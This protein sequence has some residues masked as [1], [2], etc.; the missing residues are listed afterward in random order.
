VSFLECLL[1]R[2]DRRM[3]DVVEDAWRSGARFDSWDDR[4]RWDVWTEVLGRHEEIPIEQL[5]GT[6]PVDATLPW[7]HLDIGIEKRFLAKEYRQAM[8]GRASPPCGK[9]V[10][11]QTHHTNLE[12]HDADGRKLVCYACGVECDLSAMREE[13]GG[14]LRKLGAVEAPRRTAEPEGVTTGRT[15]PRG[16]PPHDFRQGDPVRYRLHL[17]RLPPATLVGHLDWIRAL[18]RILRRAGLPLFYSEGFHPKPKM[19]FPPALPL[20][21]TS[22]DEAVDIAL[23]EERDPE[24]VLAA[25]REAA[26]EGIAFR[27][28]LRRE[29]DAKRLNRQIAV[30][31]WIARLRGPEGDHADAPA[32]LLARESIPW[33]VTRRRRPKEVDLRPRSRTCDGSRRPSCR[34]VSRGSA[35]TAIAGCGSGSSTTSPASTDAPRRWWRR[36]SRTRRGWSPP[37]WR[38]SA[39]WRARGT[40]S[41]PSPPG[42]H[43]RGR[44][45]DASPRA[46]SGMRGGNAPQV[47]TSNRGRRGAPPRI[48]GGRRRAPGACSGGLRR[49]PRGGAR[50]YRRRG[51]VPPCRA[52]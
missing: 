48:R 20:G 42:E 9:P 32:R 24:E 26:P 38:G 50:S 34:S 49:R 52:A 5:V 46:L 37:T 29:V 51:G 27:T 40:C 36:C 13:R 35:G 47:F 41:S 3:A 31:E 39:S 44:F 25:L 33:T 14:Y 45:R 28:V 4:L 17:D 8:K 7:D 22:L 6:F 18:P 19:E 1:G 12:E 43:F 15:D 11:L 21:T 30:I 10:G 2:G 16:R 23:T